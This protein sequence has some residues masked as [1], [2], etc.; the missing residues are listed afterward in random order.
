MPPAALPR[1]INATHSRVLL[2]E[3]TSRMC[4]LVLLI[5]SILGATHSQVSQGPAKPKV[6]ATYHTGDK[7]FDIVQRLDSLVVTHRDTA[8][9]SLEAFTS[10]V[11]DWEWIYDTTHHYGFALPPF[12]AFNEDKYI[13]EGRGRKFEIGWITKLTALTGEEF[14]VFRTHCNLQIL[15]G[16][17]ESV[18]SGFEFHEDRW[19]APGRHGILSPAELVTTERWKALRAKTV[20]GKYDSSGVYAGL[21][22]D[23]PRLTAIVEGPNGWF[24]VWTLYDFDA[25]KEELFFRIVDASMFIR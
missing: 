9:I 6:I 8:K 21:E 19:F 18:A 3:I 25:M 22:F 15:R 7:V 14:V 23:I 10:A 13:L 20:G 16:T 12:L 1:R 2:A 24:A 17:F 4:L 5:V 11:R